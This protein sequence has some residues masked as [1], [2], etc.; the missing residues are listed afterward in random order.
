MILVP[1]DR[2]LE[3]LDTDAQQVQLVTASLAIVLSLDW[4]NRRAY[5]CF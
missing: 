2:L 1:S 5:G 4:G 3:E